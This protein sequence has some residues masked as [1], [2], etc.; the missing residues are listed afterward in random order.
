[1]VDGEQLRIQENIFYTYV[2]NQK[3]SYFPLK[4]TYEKKE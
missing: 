4:F 3:V 1:M 2:D